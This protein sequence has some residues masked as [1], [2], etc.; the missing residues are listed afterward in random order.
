MTTTV[1]LPPGLEQSLRRQ[2]A[3]EGRSISEVMRDA[4]TAYLAQVPTAHYLF[5]EPDVR[6]AVANAATDLAPTEVP[7]AGT[8]DPARD[9]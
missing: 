6:R 1:K 8:P 9:D 2:C 4:L 7:A 5:I 3:A